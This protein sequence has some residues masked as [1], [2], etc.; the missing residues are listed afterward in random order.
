MQHPDYKT[1]S[2]LIDKER[3][4]YCDSS[5]V[6]GGEGGLL[7]IE[8]ESF[9]LMWSLICATCIVKLLYQDLE[10]VENYYKERISYPEYKNDLIRGLNEIKKAPGQLI[11]EQIIYTIKN[12]KKD[13]LGLDTF[14]FFYFLFFIFSFFFFLFI[15]KIKVS[16]NVRTTLPPYAIKALKDIDIKK[17]KIPDLNRNETPKHLDDENKVDE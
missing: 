1:A 4:V 5:I 10:T 14:F 9:V 11:C 15:A 16:D 17:V 7:K 12:G 2:I 8:T 13:E 3:V 6:E